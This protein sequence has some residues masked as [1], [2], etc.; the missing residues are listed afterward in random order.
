VP[1]SDRSRSRAT[2]PPGRALAALLLAAGGALGG[3]ASGVRD[4][5]R[6][7]AA[8]AA[9]RSSDRPAAVKA[10]APA[11]R[12]LGG[13]A[14]EV[15]VPAS[16]LRGANGL[17][18]TGGRL[19]VASA[20]GDAI[21]EVTAAGAV[22]PIAVP[23][24]LTAPD[25]LAF[26]PEGDLL[27]TSMRGGSVWRRS[28][29]GTWREVAGA[30]PGANGIA[31][32]KDGRIFA[33]QCFFADAVTEITSDGAAPRTIARELGCPNGLFVD[34]A[35][36]L[37]VPLLEKGEL[38]RID[39]Q[40]GAIT[41]LRGGLAQ[42]TAAE[43]D[44]D[45][46]ILVLEGASGAILRLDPVESGTPA[47]PSKVTALAPGL[48]NLTFCGESL[49]V[50]NFLTGAIHAFK[51][52]PGEARTLVPGGL[53]SPR[54]LLFHAGELLVADGLSVKQL[55]DGRAPEV[56][57]GVLLDPLPFPVG[58]AG[59]GSG[60]LYVSSPEEGSVHRL[61]RASR[62][63]EL[64]AD[65]LEW[66]TSLAVTPGGDLLVAET[67]AG[68]VLRIDPT[69]LR[70]TLA[71]GLLSPVGLAVL[72]DRVLTAEPAGGRVLALRAGEL[73]A[74]VASEL[75][76]PA[77]LAVDARGDVFV[78]EAAA[79]RLVRVGSGGATIPIA[80]GLALEAGETALP[81]PIGLAVDA[82]GGV[83]V[84]SPA[85]GSVVRFAER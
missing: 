44:R 67:G 84:A 57:F 73:P 17:A 25:D 5:A 55:R 59:D 41:R 80:T 43:S 52:W 66:P 29:D 62:T 78:A 49:L 22:V 79:G 8:L 2:A 18:C 9:A 58:L 38:V 82:D 33:T 4:E 19:F 21:A 50:S 83:V 3:C 60:R 1:P 15:V 23:D 10:A 63:V 30:L 24:A 11:L 68:R 71:S 46:G 65:G 13:A 40:N 20:A 48:D 27:A 14:A 54:A 34:R 37:V 74:V 85:D 42:P 32:A 39:P 69:G 26:T 7:E 28:R 77:G 56:L 31:V 35:G 70:E 61:D 51:P 47:E 75:A 64:V 12:A 36:S 72:Q 6:I 45:G 53:I 16:P 81:L 76:W